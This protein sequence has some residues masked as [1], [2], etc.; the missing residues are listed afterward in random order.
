MS[1]FFQKLKILIRKHII[2]VS[3]LAMVVFAALAFLEIKGLLNIDVS[4]RS[5]PIEVSDVV[6]VLATILLTGLVSGFYNWQVSRSLTQ[7]RNSEAALKRERDLLEQKMK[8]RTREL[9]KLEI[10]KMMRLYR[11]AEFGRIAS[12]LFHDLVN[13]LTSASLQLEQ[14]QLHNDASQSVEKAL[15]GLRRMEHFIV[16]AR[17]QVQEEDVVGHFSLS[18]EIRHAIEILSFKARKMQV[19]L[20]FLEDEDVKIYGSPLKF[21]QIVTNLISNAIDAYAH[22]AKPATKKKVVIHLNVYPKKKQAV[23]EIRDWGSGIAPEVQDLIFEPLFTTKESNVGVGLG[24]S[25]TKKIIEEDFGGKITFVSQPRL[26]TVFTIE[27]P[28]SSKLGPYK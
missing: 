16:A 1:L 25:I 17:K 4:W 9:Q 18:M 6:F 19:K 11:Y 12:G 7:A 24:L 27:L 3:F 10:E 13:P 28:F 2:G 22:S 21:G 15:K 5:D 23:L 8:E 14:F 20:E 26:V